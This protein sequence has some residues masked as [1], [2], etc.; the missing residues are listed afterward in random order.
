MDADSRYIVVSIDSHVGPPI[1]EYGEYCPAE[2]RAVFDEQVK[3]VA[4][5]R[6]NGANFNDVAK[7]SLGYSLPEKVIAAAERANAVAG[8]NDI[9]ARLADMDHDGVAASVV[10]HGL[11]NGE[12][13]PLVSE[14]LF[15][16]TTQRHELDSVGCHMYNQWVADFVSAAP[17][18]FAPLAY[19]NMRN[20]DDAVKELEW[21][22]NAGLRGVNFPAP[23]ASRPA[24]SDP[25]YDRLFAAAADLDMA[26]TTHR[27]GGD[28]WNYEDG[29]MGAAYQR[30]EGGF[31]GQRGIWQLIFSGVLERHPKLKVVLTEFLSTHWVE[32]ILRDMDTVMLDQSNPLS[33]S[34]K[35]L[36]SEYWD[37]NF[38]VG[39]SF[40]AH[41]E[42]EQFTGRGMS[43][44]MWGDD[45]P[46]SE[47]TYPFTRESMRT[48]FAGLPA[49]HTERMIGMTAAECYGLDIEK[50]R[51]VADRIGPTVA[52]L[53]T[54]PDTGPDD[55][56]VG[57]G[58]RESSVW[59]AGSLTSS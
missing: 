2:H 21:A 29:L 27:G 22:A 28:R 33:G 36:P 46:H 26:L 52:E 14:A 38:F 12:P 34:L 31:V 41:D 56:Y 54:R 50:L 30:I 4:S 19:V 7:R 10:F 18:R 49:E 25:M 47:G 44:V 11:Q 43:G 58:F 39:A 6:S 17:H 9:H 1:E 45:Y 57:F 24:Y 53:S 51:T 42:A 20:V 3:H 13:M 59:P 55:A 35:K 15:Q 16:A 8:G 48:T 32:G 37:T 40:L 5:L 23:V